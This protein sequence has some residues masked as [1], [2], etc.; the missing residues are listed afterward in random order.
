MWVH[1]I[2][3]DMDAGAVIQRSVALAHEGIVEI[4]VEK[5]CTLVERTDE[6]LVPADLLIAHLLIEEHL[7]GVVEV[8]RRH[9]HIHSRVQ[10]H[11]LR[12]QWVD[13]AGRFGQGAAGAIARMEGR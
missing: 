8:H 10:S 11:V 1:A 12:Q 7:I 5:A 6:A 2:A 4:G 13:R 3:H 9:A